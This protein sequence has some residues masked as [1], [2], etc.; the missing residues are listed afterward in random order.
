MPRIKPDEIQFE[1]LVL[2]RET[3]VPNQEN[4][5]DLNT[6]ME[7]LNS[8]DIV[9]MTNVEQNLQNRQRHLN[10]AKF[11][12]VCNPDDTVT[13]NEKYLCEMSKAPNGWPVIPLNISKKLE[14]SFKGDFI[15]DYMK[16]YLKIFREY[17]N[18]FKGVA[19]ELDSPL[20]PEDFLAKNN[21]TNNNNNDLSVFYFFQNPTNRSDTEFDGDFFV[22]INKSK[23]GVF[24]KLTTGT[25]TY[26]VNF[27]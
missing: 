3:F 26:T 19:I 6:K 14:G 4:F 10:E 20:L 2:D 25:I 18:C 12:F 13:E 24:Y 17:T 22:W 23:P 5:S 16:K 9:I 21:L 8:G 15:Q 7:H 11:Y 1:T 27:R